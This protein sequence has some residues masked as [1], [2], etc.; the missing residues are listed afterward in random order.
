VKKGDKAAGKRQ[1]QPLTIKAVQQS[2]LEAL[3]ALKCDVMEQVDKKFNTANELFERADRKINQANDKLN[4][5]SMNLKRL[6]TSVHNDLGT[7]DLRIET[8][9]SMLGIGDKAPKI[10]LLNRLTD[11]ESQW[12]FVFGNP[13]KCLDDKVQELEKKIDNFISG[14]L[15]VP[16]HV[17]LSGHSSTSPDGISTQYRIMDRAIAEINGSKVRILEQPSRHG[18]W[19]RET[20]SDGIEKPLP[21]YSKDVQPAIA[22]FFRAGGQCIL[23]A[24]SRDNYGYWLVWTEG[25]PKNIKDLDARLICN[26]IVAHAKGAK[27]A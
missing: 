18:N 16:A 27:N 11:L 9:E 6:G 25:S 21:Y 15:K 20:D 4:E 1:K 22:A 12:K 8:C 14:K 19:C 5:E 26:E 7:V 24:G 23:P 2:M 3:L 10:N 17:S 13:D